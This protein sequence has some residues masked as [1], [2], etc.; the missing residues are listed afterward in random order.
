M[1]DGTALGSGVARG[2]AGQDGR[3]LASLSFDLDN[4][5]AYLRTHGDRGWE[6]YPSYLEVVVPRV[7]SFLEERGLVITVFVVGKDAAAAQNRTLFRAIAAAGHE[8]G[9]HSFRHEPCLHMYGEEELESEVAT[10]EEAISEVAGQRPVGFRGPGYSLSEGTLR[11]LV[12]RGYLY[13]ATT[14]PSFVGPLARA[15]YFRRARLG[16]AERAQRECL[17]GSF[18]DGLRPLRPYRWRLGGATL[19]ELP[20]TTMPILRLPIH[21]SYL[22]YLSTFS[23]RL[24]C[25]YWAAALRLCRL[26]GVAPSLLLHPLDFLGAGEIRG[27]AFFPGMGL[28]GAEKIRRVSA[29]LAALAGEFKIQTLRQH[30]AA[31]TDG[32]PLSVLDP[33]FAVGT[34]LVPSGESL[35]APS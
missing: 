13:D 11:V 5:W 34:R 22:L 2:S 24:A 3:S 32:R 25:V 29:Y 31:V 33:R 10:A 20:I 35:P 19:V 21:M 16:G 27:L 9:N 7:L 30:F 8:L 1:E 18:K 23:E 26:R 14:L 6:S 4:L 12:R 28:P 17:F 15:Y